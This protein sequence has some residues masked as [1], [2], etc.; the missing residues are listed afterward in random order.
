MDLQEIF[1]CFVFMHEYARK[2]IELYV[3]DGDDASTGDNNSEETTLNICSHCRQH[4]D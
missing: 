1:D 2:Y 4:M 3:L